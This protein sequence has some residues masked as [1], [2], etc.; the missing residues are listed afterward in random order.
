VTI[1]ETDDAELYNQPADIF[2][3]KEAGQ[4][5]YEAYIRVGTS[6][7][8]AL[9]IRQRSLGEVTA[10]RG[11][12]KKLQAFMYLLEG[13]ANDRFLPILT[14]EADAQQNKLRALLSG[15]ADDDGGDDDGGLPS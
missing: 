7:T 15:T 11:L 12:T 2:S 4:E 10:I 6:G 5:I 3:R 1:I 9:I 13:T 8:R 14:A